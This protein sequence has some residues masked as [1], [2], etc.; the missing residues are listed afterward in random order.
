MILQIV[1]SETL[2]RFAIGL[3]YKMLRNAEG[4]IK[5]VQN[6]SLF[7]QMIILTTLWHLIF[8]TCDNYIWDP[9][10]EHG[11]SKSSKHGFYWLNERS[12]E[13]DR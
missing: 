1:Q 10:V 9:T 4:Q 8:T 3:G 13:G 5:H 11:F 2:F 6:T 7:L 12:P